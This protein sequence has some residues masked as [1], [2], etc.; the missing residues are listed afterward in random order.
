M[1]QVNISLERHALNFEEGE[2]EEH[3]SNRG[4]RQAAASMD[5]EDLVAGAAVARASQRAPVGANELVWEVLSVEPCIASG[6][7]SRISDREVH[8]KIEQ[9]PLRLMRLLE[10]SQRANE[11][12]K[13]DSL[14]GLP[15][16]GKARYTWSVRLDKAGKTHAML[17]YAALCFAARVFFNSFMRFLI[18]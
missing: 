18:A 1:I 5:I 12:A 6:Y 14:S 10:Q 11:Q 3:Q 9:R 4:T 8:I 15:S 17:C 13:L 2:K 7:V 16:R